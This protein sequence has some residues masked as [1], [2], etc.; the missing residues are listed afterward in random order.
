MDNPDVLPYYMEA[1]KSGYA[2]TRKRGPRNVPEEE[3]I[4]EEASD[5]DSVDATE[6]GDTGEG[7]GEAAREDPLEEH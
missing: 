6:Q 7:S 4:S 5:R 3:V 2:G 1:V